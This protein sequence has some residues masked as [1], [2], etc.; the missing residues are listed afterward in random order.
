M[1]TP[2]RPEWITDRMLGLA[3]HARRAA[4]EGRLSP[5]VRRPEDPDL[6]AAFEDVFL[7]CGHA[8]LELDQHVTHDRSRGALVGN[9]LVAVSMAEALAAGDQE[10][11]HELMPTTVPE[12]VAVVSTLAGLLKQVVKAQHPGLEQEAYAELRELLIANDAR[13]PD[14]Q[15]DDDD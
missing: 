5:S 2:P 12:L 10:R 7:L 3:Q 8:L 4:V 1:T 9:Q 6:A 14:E 15:G 11:M 13:T